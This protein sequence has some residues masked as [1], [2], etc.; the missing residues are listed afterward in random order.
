MTYV[1]LTGGA[2]LSVGSVAALAV[3]VRA[4][5][6]ELG[7]QRPWGHGAVPRW[8][9][10]R[11]LA[12]FVA[13][14]AVPSSC[15]P[16]WSL[17]HHPGPHGHLAAWPHPV[18]RRGHAPLGD[19]FNWVG[20]GYVGKEITAVLVVLSA[21]AALW[22]IL[23]NRRGRD[24]VAAGVTA[25]ATGAA[26]YSFMG[27][28]GAPVPALLFAALALAAHFIL[29]NT[30]WGRYIVAAGSNPQ[31]AFLSGVP[32]NRIIFFIYLLMGL[33]S[34]V[35]GAVLSARLNGAM[36]SAGDLFELDAIAAVV[37][38]T[39]LTGARL[40][41]TVLGAFLIGTL[42]NG[43]SLQHRRPYQKVI[44]GVIIISAVW[45]DTCGR[46]KRVRNGFA[47]SGP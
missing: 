40:S 37:I 39:R 25:A 21:A 20:Q 46:D 9:R 36:P 8:Q 10:L 35:A 22:R 18:P 1:I 4:S 41:V 47:R 30:V 23:S 43:M 3:V 15:A 24:W 44:K 38:G 14:S 17:H 29:Q 31:A 16:K 2:D 5:C 45:L 32:V 33:L 12:R 26:L 7:L 34:G 6:S 19:D 27:Y 42:N 13:C 28:R 11:P